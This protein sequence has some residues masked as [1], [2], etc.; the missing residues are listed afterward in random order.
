LSY[1]Y[2]CLYWI[3]FNQ[4][5]ADLFMALVRHNSTTVC[6]FFS[7]NKMCGNLKKW[8]AAPNHNAHTHTHTHTENDN[9]NIHQKSKLILNNKVESVVIK[10]LLYLLP[11]F[12]EWFKW[13]IKNHRSLGTKNRS[14]QI[15]TNAY[16]SF[17]PSYLSIHHRFFV[18]GIFM[19]SQ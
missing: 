19:K 13:K 5:I 4:S 18:L 15:E 10:V 1:R 2:S 16:H 7:L 14:H 11:K 12:K 17:L 8:D 3:F 6:S 9:G